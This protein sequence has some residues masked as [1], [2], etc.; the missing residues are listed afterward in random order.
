M[1]ADFVNENVLDPIQAFCELSFIPAGSAKLTVNGAKATLDLSKL[2]KKGTFNSPHVMPPATTGT[3]NTSWFQDSP[4]LGT[5]GVVL[6]VVV[7]FDSVTGNPIFRSLGF[8]N[9]GVLYTISPQG[10]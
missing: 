1:E 4:P 9:L 7:G 3:D 8:D 2:A 6:R 5:D 10:F